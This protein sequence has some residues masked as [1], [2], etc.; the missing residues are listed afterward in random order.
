MQL[1][2]TEDYNKT[3]LS[4][5][6]FSGVAGGGISNSTT[7]QKS[8]HS[9]SLIHLAIQILSKWTLWHLTYL[10]ELFILNFQTQNN[11]LINSETD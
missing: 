11:N 6:S 1:A 3:T 4:A 10:N 5:D 9:K 2:L 8:A 7:Q